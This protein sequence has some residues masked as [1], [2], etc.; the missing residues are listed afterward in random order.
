ME[1]KTLQDT[2]TGSDR[3]LEDLKIAPLKPHTDHSERL[4]VGKN[5]YIE[6]SNNESKLA[7]KWQEVQTKR[8]AD[9]RSHC[10]VLSLG[11]DAQVIIC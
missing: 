5:P 2:A 10:F 9:F 3:L 4:T 1:F 6:F 7:T 8:Y 11:M